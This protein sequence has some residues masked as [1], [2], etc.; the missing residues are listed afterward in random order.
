MSNAQGGNT[1]SPAR[2]V[3]HPA[4]DQRVARSAVDLLLR[5]GHADVGKPS[6]NGTAPSRHGEGLDEVG[7]VPDAE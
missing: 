5:L 4:R 6:I 1:R 3:S 2:Q 7:E